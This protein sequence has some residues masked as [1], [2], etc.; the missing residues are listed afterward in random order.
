MTTE[1]CTMLAASTS[2]HPAAGLLWSRGGHAHMLRAGSQ[3]SM[4]EAPTI[5]PMFRMASRTI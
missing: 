4:S 2:D 3:H 5:F 1:I